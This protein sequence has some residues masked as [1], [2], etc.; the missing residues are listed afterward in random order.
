M[1]VV[2]RTSRIHPASFE[3]TGSDV[4]RQIL[5]CLLIVSGNALLADDVPTTSP[6]TGQPDQLAQA[7]VP[8]PTAVLQS[9]LTATSGALPPS[10]EP[11]TAPP[12]VVSPNGAALPPPNTSQYQ[13]GMV[14]PPG[15]C[16]TCGGAPQYG[17][18]MGAPMGMPMGPP[19]GMVPPGGLVAPGMMQSGFPYSARRPT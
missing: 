17:M 9:P 2:Q 13:P 8:I 12:M 5:F 6:M 18:P 1:A 3:K 15:S 11:L 10:A 4:K 14:A 7:T 19:M 16:P